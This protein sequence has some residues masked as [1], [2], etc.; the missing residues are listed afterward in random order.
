MRLDHHVDA[1]DVACIGQPV[2]RHAIGARD[3]RAFKQRINGERRLAALP[4]FKPVVGKARELLRPWQ[5]RIDGDPARGQPVLIVGTRR[6]EVGRTHG[7]EPVG[8]QVLRHDAETRKSC[9][10]LE[11]VCR[12]DLGNIEQRIGIKHL[13]RFSALHDVHMNGLF[14]VTPEVE[15][16]R[17]DAPVRFQPDALGRLVADLL[18]LIVVDRFEHFGRRDDGRDIGQSRFLRRQRTQRLE[19]EWLC[20]AQFSGLKARHCQGVWTDAQSCEH[21]GCG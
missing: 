10:S 9:A 15:E 4:A 17:R 18:V 8:L 20:L 21:G 2:G 19:R 12:V 11:L 14:R 3:A 5:S 16:L 6:A 7:R 1:M 13:A